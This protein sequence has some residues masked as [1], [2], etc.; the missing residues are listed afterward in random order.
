[1]LCTIFRNIYN[2]KELSNW[3]HTI[4]LKYELRGMHSLA[5]CWSAYDLYV[6][7]IW[8]LW[9]RIVIYIFLASF[10]EAKFGRISWW[11]RQ[12]PWRLL[13][14]FVFFEYPFSLIGSE[15][16]N[17]A[18]SHHEQI[19]W[20]VSPICLM[21]FPQIFHV[22]ISL[23]GEH[24]FILVLLHDVVIVVVQKRVILGTPINYYFISFLRGGATTSL[25]LVTA[26]LSL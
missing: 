7:T 26:L 14:L 9:D 25:R 22:I 24:W 23:F 15:L 20:L 18:H 12:P 19:S 21:L 10:R 6:A 13:L 3:L 17:L 5:P 11:M 1:M 4:S 8:R 2:F 16:L